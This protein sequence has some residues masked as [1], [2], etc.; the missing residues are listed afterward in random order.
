MGVSVDSAVE[1]DCRPRIDSR[2]RTETPVYKGGFACNAPATSLSNGS[3]GLLG[4]IS[5][6][7]S[8]PEVLRYNY[9][10]PGN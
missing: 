7:V 8:D 9:A 4:A 2:R 3:V 1:I 6:R 5:F 10:R